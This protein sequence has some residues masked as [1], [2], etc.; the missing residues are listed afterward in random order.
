M[1]LSFETKLDFDHTV[2]TEAR[3]KIRKF[4]E[5]FVGTVNNEAHNEISKYVSDALT[6]Q[7]L[8]EFVQQK[9]YYLKSLHRKFYGRRSNY[10]RLPALKLSF[11]NEKYQLAGE[12]EEYSQGVLTGNGDIKIFLLN[13]PENNFQI[14]KIIFYPRM[15]AAEFYE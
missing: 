1:S 2:E 10:F 14:S 8:S 12:Y 7:G 6:V 5:S 4:I 11:E 15:R 9:D 13:M 3:F